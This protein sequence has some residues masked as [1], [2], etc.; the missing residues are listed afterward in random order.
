MPDTNLPFVIAPSNA[1]LKLV[2]DEFGDTSVEFAAWYKDESRYEA[3][4]ITFSRAICSRSVSWLNTESKN[5]IGALERN[6]SQWLAELNNAQ[7]K[8]YPNHPDNF[9]SM[10]HYY[11]G[12]HDC[13]VEVIAEGFEW[14]TL[15]QLEGR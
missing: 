3:I 6:A 1:C 8:R 12:A 2:A 4:R 5:G 15:Q 7:A 11:F 14:V 10:N 13:A 9:K